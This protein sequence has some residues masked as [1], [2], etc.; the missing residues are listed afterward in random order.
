MIKILSI[1]KYWKA[2]GIVLLTAGFL[3]SA[4]LA[5]SRG[6]KL[7]TVQE[8]LNAERQKFS[9]QIKIIEKE[10]Q[11]EKEREGFRR[12]QNRKIKLADNDSLRSA[13]DSLR[14]RAN[15]AIAR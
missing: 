3:V 8:T 14:D 9:A 6:E 10:K 13:Y 5:K 7:Q 4:Q 15:S 2:G 11:D 12:K 1:L